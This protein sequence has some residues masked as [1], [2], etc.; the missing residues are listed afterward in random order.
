MS[1]P[2]S[3]GSLRASLSR[4]TSPA[5]R[6][7]GERIFSSGRV[8][9]V[10]RDDE[11]SEYLFA[12]TIGSAARFEVHLWPDDSEWECDCEVAACAHAYASLLALEGGLDSVAAAVEPPR[13]VGQIE[14]AEG[15]LSLR[16]EVRDGERLLPFGGTLPPGLEVPVEITRLLRL[17]RDWIDGRIPGRGHRVFLSAMRSLDELHLDNQPIEASRVALD[18]VARVEATGV[19]YRLSLS[20]PPQVTQVWEGDPT[21]VLAE[22]VLRPRGFGKLSALQKH[23]LARP[24]LFAEHELPRLTAEWVPA[25]QKAIEVIQDE[26]VPQTGPGGLHTLLELNRRGDCL[27]VCARI[28]YGDP[29]VAELRGEE[30]IPLGG[31]HSVPARSRPAEREALAELHGEMGLRAGQ[32][33]RLEGQAALRFVADRL[34]NFDGLVLGEEVARQFTLRG[35]ALRPELDW[36]EGLQ[37]GFVGGEVR[38]GASV[39]LAAWRRGESVVP[40]AGGGFGSLPVDWLQDHGDSLELLLGSLGDGACPA[41]LAPLALSLGARIDAKATFDPRPLLATLRGESPLPEPSLPESLEGV[42]RDYQ[43]AGFRWLHFLGHHGLGGVLADDMG[44]GKTLQALA[45]L[46]TSSEAG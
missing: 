14:S 19:G 21:L 28:V 35:E 12:V 3:I 33:L 16:L 40:L 46:A 29:P 36:G 24:L 41:H 31:L 20:D 42:L 38:V 37:A 39:A 15:R 45:L 26:R 1:S 43:A 2:Q 30:L 11:A 44:L 18:Q 9:L 5:L 25:L 27:E 17:S 7:V 32:R 34:P 22:G 13:L 8:A 4:A 6:R 10:T 23:Q